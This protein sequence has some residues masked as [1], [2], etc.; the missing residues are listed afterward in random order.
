[1]PN[2][3]AD[4]LIDIAKALLTAAGASDE[5]ARAIAAYLYTLK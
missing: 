4:R 1:M 2:V 5:E 3:S